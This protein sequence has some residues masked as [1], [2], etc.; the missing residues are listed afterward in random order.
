[1]HLKE[2][3]HTDY[4]ELLFRIINDRSNKSE[5]IEVELSSCNNQSVLATILRCLTSLSSYHSFNSR[6][7]PQR[8]CYKPQI[9]QQLKFG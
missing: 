1:M 5:V 3:C 9:R 6:I 4:T 7:V 2:V 8:L